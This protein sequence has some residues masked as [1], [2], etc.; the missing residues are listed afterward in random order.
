MFNICPP[1]GGGRSEHPFRWP[2]GH[3]ASLKPEAAPK[4]SLPQS[5]FSPPGALVQMGR[6]KGSGDHITQ[7]LKLKHDRLD[8]H[9]LANR[10]LMYVVSTEVECLFL[11]K[12]MNC[13]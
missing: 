11:Q 13:K 1:T 9:F 7:G 6:R 5:G 4:K 2:T 3:Q 10:Q 12:I 8:M